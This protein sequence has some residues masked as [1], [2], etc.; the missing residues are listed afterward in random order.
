[1]ATKKRTGK[2]AATAAAITVMALLA[3]CG[4]SAVEEPVGA[5]PDSSSVVSTAADTTGVVAAP[6]TTSTGGTGNPGVNTGGA[7][8]AGGTTADTKTKA[9]TGGGNADLSDTQ[10]RDRTTGAAGGTAGAVE[11]L[12]KSAPIFGGKA[13]CKPATLSEI[14]VGNVSTLSGVL[15]ELFSPVVPALETFVTSQNA[16]GGLNGHRIKYFQSDDQGDPSTAVTKV[17][18]MIQK[19]KV[20]AFVGNIQVLTLDA[21]APTIRKFGIPIIGG[22]STSNTWFLSQFLFPQGAPVQS[23]GYGYMEAATKYFKVKNIGNIYCIEVP[24][25]CE[26]IDRAM[27]ELAPR[28]GLVMSKSIQASITAP[29]YVQQCIEFKN[30]GVEALG[31]DVDAASMVRIAR[32]CTQVGFHPKVMAYPLAVGNEKQ[33]L[34]NKWLGDAYVPMNVFPWMDDST[35]A[36]KY[37]QASVKR[38][39][40]GFDSGGAASLGWS[41]GALLVAA[42][43]QLSPTNP[44]TEQ[45]LDALYQFKGQSFTTLGGLTTPRT[46]TRDGFPKVPYC[47]FA[48]IS[49]ADNTGWST[50]ISKPT[51]TDVLAP[52]DPQANR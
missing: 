28:F 41:A 27:K 51:C 50:V 45:F 34:G 4:G 35:P 38:Y 32:S 18:E 6:T 15:G 14:N 5:A 23:V 22:D 2:F 47:L 48:A 33:F 10:Q 43:A 31:L 17:Q 29:S 52:S 46:F 21:V 8:Q 40:P 7:V 24:R 1:M 26:G 44:T 19:N 11:T 3:G 25:Q 30:A 20:L 12:V 13:A 16:C 36:T 9:N 49:N 37:Y 39:N 42:S